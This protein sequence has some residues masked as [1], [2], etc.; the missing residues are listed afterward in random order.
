M[1]CSSSR[2]SHVFNVIE[3]LKSSVAVPSPH[4]KSRTLARGFKLYPIQW[5]EPFGL[6]MVEAMACGTPVLASRGIHW[7]GRSSGQER[8]LRKLDGQAHQESLPKLRTIHH[9]IDLK[10]YVEGGSCSRVETKMLS[11]AHTLIP[12]LEPFGGRRHWHNNRPRRNA[13]CTN[14]GKT[15]KG[16]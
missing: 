12:F 15:V 3:S 16:S 8:A 14:R 1:S 7:S 4:F 6:V 11:D 2:S 5:H 10:L 13:G 9:G